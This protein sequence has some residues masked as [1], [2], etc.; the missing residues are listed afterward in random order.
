[1]HRLNLSK[2]EIR[3]C[4]LRSLCVSVFLLLCFS[5]MHLVDDTIWAVS[6]AATSFIAFAFPKADSVKT[7][8]LIGSYL[9]SGVF[10]TIASLL[11]RL[12][13]RSY[14]PSIVLCIVVIFIVSFGMTLF[15]LEHP[16]AAAF[17]V[18][19]TLFEMPIVYALFA[20]ASVAVL[21]L[22]KMPLARLVLGET[23]VSNSTSFTDEPTF[24]F[25]N[26]TNV[27]DVTTTQ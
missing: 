8:V 16:P 24:E 10:G 21:C 13:G 19:L 26:D 20:I 18:G 5:A 27:S 2:E 15:D 23:K 7:R 6:L 14:M 3:L 17:A 12:I 22:I 4:L 9:M 11:L 25:N 1:M